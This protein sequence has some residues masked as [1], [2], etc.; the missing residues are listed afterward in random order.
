[1]LII[2]LSTE[3][4]LYKDQGGKALVQGMFVEFHIKGG[5]WKR[6]KSVHSTNSGTHLRRDINNLGP[7]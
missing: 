6:L 5:V 3:I 7:R 4:P 1:M 2:K